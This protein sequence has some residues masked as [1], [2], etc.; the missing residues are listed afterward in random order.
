MGK[1]HYHG[2]A[3][4]SWESSTIMGK[5]HYH[6]K[7]ALSWESSTIM[8][9][10]H[11]HGKASCQNREKVTEQI[12]IKWTICDKIVER[13]K[14]RLFPTLTN[15]F[16]SAVEKLLCHVSQRSHKEGI[17]EWTQPEN[18]EVSGYQLV[19]NRGLV[20]RAS[21]CQMYSVLILVQ[22]WWRIS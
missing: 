1:Q 10:Q 21:P 7:A 20:P 2:K 3:A 17:M 8:G 13:G 12:M 9:K 4:L 22:H 6:G 14:F 19:I 15:Y 16:I 18:R 11:Y 5:R